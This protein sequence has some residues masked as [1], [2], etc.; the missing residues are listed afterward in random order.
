VLHAP[1]LIKN[2]ISVRQ[3]TKDNSVSVEFDPCGFSVNDLQTGARLVRCDSTGDLYP[4]F[5]IN[6][7]TPPDNP[8][9]FTA[10]SSAIW[11]NRLGHP[12]PAVFRSLR[13]NN[14]IDCNKACASF[15][16]SC[17]LGKLSKLPFYESISNTASPFDIIHSDLW[18]SPIM[19]SSGHCYYVLFLDDYS[20][21]L[22][23]FPIA[24][25]SQV[26]HIFQ[27]FHNMIRTNSLV[28]SRPSNVTMAQNILMALYKSSLTLMACSFVSLVLIH[29]PKME[30]PNG[31]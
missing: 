18:T 17:P 12:G 20:K 5:S 4:L 25:K 22:W 11:H 29:H 8:T 14:F 26:K 31:T 3:F 7:A 13:R 6:Q 28:I 16:S 10:I 23:T 1:K 9:P 24:K 27:S 30:K 15:C 2:L 19:S 21:F